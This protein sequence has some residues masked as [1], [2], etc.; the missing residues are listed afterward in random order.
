M[1]KQKTERG[2]KEMIR[3]NKILSVLLIVFLATFI[4]VIFPVDV[5]ADDE[6]YDPLV[7]VSSYQI[8]DDVIIPGEDF[9]LIIE[10][11]NKDKT[12]SA[13]E[14]LINLNFPE[15]ITTVYPTL[16]QMYLESLKPGEKKEVVFNLNLSPYYQR[17]TVTF[18]VTISSGARSS[19]VNLFAPVQLNT[20]PFKILSKTVPEAAGAGEKIAVSLSFKSLLDEKLSNVIL[21][22]FVDD[23]KKPVNTANIGNLFAGASKSQ[24]VT[25]F[26][27][28]KGKHSV[29]FELSYTMAEGN[30]ATDEIYSGIIEITDPSDQ[31]VSPADEIQEEVIS[32]N[33]KLIIGGCL[34]LSFLL[35]IGIVLIIKKYN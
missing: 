5:K 23:E 7:I 28:D 31:N 24:N 8:S 1:K 18:G 19:Y 32:D 14:L 10:V 34:G 33:D 17:S 3:N 22:V 12:V 29:R 15:A 25:Y 21:S 20:S 16:N 9:D 13:R 2:E 4:K 11:E 35:A 27:Y 26:I 6:S 30:T